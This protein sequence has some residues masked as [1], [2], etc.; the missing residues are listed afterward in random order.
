VVSLNREPH[1]CYG[2][3]TATERT[4]AAEL[5]GLLWFH[6]IGGVFV[7]YQGLKV[8]E[9]DELRRSA[10]KEKVSYTVA[11]KTLLT[12]ALKASALSL[13]RSP[14]GYDRRCYGD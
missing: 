14:S 12:K 11:K 8:K 5:S 10:D 6:E 7:N 2:Q 1:F 13:T 3:N 4:D 9:A